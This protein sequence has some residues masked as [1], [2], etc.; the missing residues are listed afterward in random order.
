MRRA[1]PP[2]QSPGCL[3][4]LD[5]TSCK[6]VIGHEFSTSSTATCAPTY[7]LIGVLHGIL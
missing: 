7:R 3:D 5:A 1:T 4:L 6:A 2:S